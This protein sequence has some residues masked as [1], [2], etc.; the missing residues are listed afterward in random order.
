MLQCFYGPYSALFDKSSG[1]TISSIDL[2]ASPQV[3]MFTPRSNAWKCI[4]N[5]LYPVTIKER[6]ADD[7][8]REICVCVSATQAKKYAIKPVIL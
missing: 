6:L 7:K 4:D 1:R 3:K 2:L 8:F 5:V